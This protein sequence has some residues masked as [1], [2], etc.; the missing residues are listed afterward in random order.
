PPLCVGFAAE[1]Q[2]LAEYAQ[3]KRLAKKIPLI[4]GNLI[5]HGFGGED[6]TLVLFDE[7]GQTPLQP[8][9]KSELARTLV[10]HIARLLD[11][12]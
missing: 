11:R 1:S 2:N 4:V 3:K 10:S 7:T 9:P 6:N 8:G 5:Q 12:R